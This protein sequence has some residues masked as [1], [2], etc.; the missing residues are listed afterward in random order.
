MSSPFGETL[1]LSVWTGVWS[2]YG[3]LDLTYGEGHFDIRVTKTS[4]LVCLELQDGYGLF[5]NS[6]YADLQ[7]LIYDARMNLWVDKYTADLLKSWVQNCCH[8]GAVIGGN[9]FD[10]DTRNQS[11][12]HI[13]LHYTRQEH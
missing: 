2:I 13:A 3:V 4:W 8:I 5:H 1:F 12:L 7:Q 9:G 6:Y 10:I 11:K